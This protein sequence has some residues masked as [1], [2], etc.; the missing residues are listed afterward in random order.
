MLTWCSSTW[1]RIM[2][3]NFKSWN[4]W[5]ESDFYDN[6]SDLLTFWYHRQNHWSC[7]HSCL[8][9]LEEWLKLMSFLATQHTFQIKLQKTARCELP[10]NLLQRLCST[11]TLLMW[12]WSVK[13]QISTNLR[14]RPTMLATAFQVKVKFIDVTCVLSWSCSYFLGPLDTKEMTTLAFFQT[15]LLFQYR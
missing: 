9:C 8:K 3:P 4:C 13:W 10:K 7:R 5:V 6:P 2:D 1:D 14:N 11:Q 15:F 12:P